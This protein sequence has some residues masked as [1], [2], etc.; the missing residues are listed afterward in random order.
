MCCLEELN[1]AECGPAVTDI[2]GVAVASIPT[3]KWLN[4]SWLINISDVTLTAI[5]EHS[6]KLT[7][8]DLTGCELITGEGVRAF[9]DHESL[10]ELVL[11]SCVNVFQS[12]VELL[13]LGSQSLK[14]IKLDKRLRMWIPIATQENISR[15]W[16][17]ESRISRFPV[18]AVNGLHKMKGMNTG[19]CWMI[20]DSGLVMLSNGSTSRT[21][22]EL[23]ISERCEL[24]RFWGLVFEANESL[25]EL[26]LSLLNVSDVSLIAIAE[27][28]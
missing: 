26:D 10:E 13:V 3:L 15:F 12:D 16:A 17:P 28:C 2:G 7:V 23:I 22:K 20:K 24:D 6:Q 25:E 8:L 19:G 11:V 18:T 1:L 9:V 21:L 27:H 14:Y 5:A 4:L